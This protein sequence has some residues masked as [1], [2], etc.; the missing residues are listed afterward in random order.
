MSD[1]AAVHIWRCAGCGHAM[2]PLRL[3]CPACGADAFEPVVAGGGIVTAHT[4]QRDGSLIVTVAV[5]GGVRLVARH[6]GPDAATGERVRLEDRGA[7]HPV[8]WA[9]KAA[10]DAEGG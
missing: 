1:A 10:A 4:R 3:A 7:D 9:M 2:F 6:A 5:T 8:P